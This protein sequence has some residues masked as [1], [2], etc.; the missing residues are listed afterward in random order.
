MLKCKKWFTYQEV[1]DYNTSYK[2]IEPHNTNNA[3]DWFYNALNANNLQYYI[4]GLSSNITANTI[5]D[6]V[7]VLMQVVY[8]RHAYDYVYGIEYDYCNTEP[9]IDQSA[10]KA[11]MNNIINVINMTLPRYLPIL[12]SNAKFS[13]DPVARVGSKTT[14]V[15]R[16]NDTPQDSGLYDDDSHSTNISES[17][18]VS[19]IDSG[20]IVSRLDELFKGFRSIILEWS[21]EFNSL[22]YKEEQL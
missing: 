10:F 4:V 5:K 8:D 1:L 15:N 22:F 14:G 21:N 13:E 6:I 16:F 9:T 18:S 3:S 7:N 19:E 17:E 2:P 11:A 20:S 12:Q